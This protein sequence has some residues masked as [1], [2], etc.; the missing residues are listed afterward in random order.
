MKNFTK[1]FFIGTLVFFIL[2]FS[3][4]DSYGVNDVQ[5][6]FR[7]VKPRILTTG[8]F[9]AQTYWLEFYI[10]VK[11]SRPNTYYQQMQINLWYNQNAFVT[12]GGNA[13][14][15]T[16]GISA[17]SYYS[18]NVTMT[19]PGLINISILNGTQ[20]DPSFIPSDYF[21][22][23]PASFADLVRMR[24]KI[25]TS[26]GFSEEA[27][28]Y[29]SPSRMN[30]LGVNAEVDTTVYNTTIPY[31]SPIAFDSTK[32]LRYF[33]LG[34]VFA[35]NG[36][37]GVWTQCGTNS[38]VVDWTTAMNTSVWD[39]ATTAAA[40][41]TTGSLANKLRVH[42][43]ARLKINSGGQLT[44]TGATEINEPNGLWITTG[45]GS[46]DGSFIDNGTITYNNG[47]SVRAERYLSQGVPAGPSYNWHAF[48]PPIV[49]TTLPYFNIYMKH[50][51][52]PNHRYWYVKNTALDSV[53]ATKMKG[54]FVW[55]DPATTG[56]KTISLTGALNTGTIGPLGVTRTLISSPDYDGYNFVG[57]PY[58]SA[59]NW[60]SSGWSL[61]NIDPTMWLWNDASNVFGTFNRTTPDS[62]NGAT[63]F[64][65]P[66]QGFYVHCNNV[67]GGSL[68]V[69]NTARQHKSVNFLKNEGG[70][71]DR[72]LLTASGNGGKDESIIRFFPE[73]TTNLDVDFDAQ[74]MFSHTE[75]PELY[76]QLQD[77][78][79]SINVRPWDGVNTL[80]PMGF[81]CSVAGNYTLTAS[82]MESFR[83]GTKVF[84]E[85]KQ[86]AGAQW[87]ELTVTPTYEFTYT[88]NEDPNRFILHF[89]NPYFGIEEQAVNSLQLYSF[90]DF[91]YVKSITNKAVSG[92][93]FI[94]DLIG[95][96]VF[97]DDLHNL[98]LNKYQPGVKE[99]YYVVRV[100]T[101]ENTY[102]QKV[103][104]K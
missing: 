6:T 83:S 104:L 69:N 91:V 28:L 85:D 49:T 22:R 89:Y 19:A 66:M 62:T 11:A 47:G 70:Y 40:I 42:K 51:D 37:I 12:G 29:I 10:Q 88:L 94:Y 5:L 46:P 45:T 68:T 3:K 16:T 38:A 32:Y 31:I 76:S 80:V 55:S 36:T 96:K 59:T 44:C 1:L 18:T 102:N 34:R 48:S 92:T 87:T 8:T 50:Y 74:K 21:T 61:T 72:L 81:T 53:L 20:Y 79:A 9:P 58:P 25:A 82:N 15:F 95:R 65:P 26:T 17:L 35:D 27:G 30:V 103:Y 99:G 63:R 86:V 97:Q 24:V 39:T 93:V 90:E 60:T 71:L 78:M 14:G 4:S 75:A 77:G 73:A 100:I 56:N 52:E 98:T 84:L 67:A 57:N 2:I 43:T 54:Y 13:Q 64:I 23:V 33:Y 7:V 101:P 41:T